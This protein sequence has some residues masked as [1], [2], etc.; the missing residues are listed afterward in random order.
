VIAVNQ[1]PLGTQ[2]TRRQIPLPLSQLINGTTVSVIPC[3]N[4]ANQ[5]WYINSTDQT[6]R[7]SLTGGCLEI[8]DCTADSV[9]AQVGPC[10]PTNPPCN[11]LNQKWSVNTTTNI[12]MNLGTKQCVGPWNTAGP[13]TVQT[14]CR[15]NQFIYNS[16]EQQFENLGAWD[17]FYGGCLNA[18]LTSGLE[19]WF[20]PL[21]DGTTALILFNQS[22]NTATI[23][24]TF[25]E[26]ELPGTTY[27][28]RDLWAHSELGKFT[29][30]F[31][32]SV[33]SHAVVMV[34]LT[35]AS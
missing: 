8:P 2:A 11:G 22:P 3:T 32:S 23:T 31:S 20:T 30:S 6:I 34:K 9:I 25:D 21:S 19:I 7:N 1:D 17:A 35:P 28:A 5:K 16:A 4:S 14:S 27:S 10:N 26:I 12:L 18:D 24:A 15:P 13:Q 29:G 33:R